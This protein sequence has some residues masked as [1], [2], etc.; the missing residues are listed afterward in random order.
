MGWPMG[1]EMIWE[2]RRADY[3]PE[4]RGF[5]ADLSV[6]TIAP[7]RTIAHG[8]TQLRGLTGGEAEREFL[9]LDTSGQAVTIIKRDAET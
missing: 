9:G 5:A 3:A 8:P 2:M 7:P 1:W 4:G 6:R